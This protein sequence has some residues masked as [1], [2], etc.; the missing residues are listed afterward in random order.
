MNLKQNEINPEEI[1]KKEVEV[2]KPNLQPEKI[3]E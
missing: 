3:E 2:P 1:I